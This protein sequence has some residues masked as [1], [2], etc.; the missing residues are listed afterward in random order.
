M[1]KKALITGIRGQDGAYLAKF[2]LNKGYTVIGADRRNSEASNW[3][4]KEI[5][6]YNKI[7]FVYLDLLEFSNI[8]EIL[9]EI[10]P[11][12]IYNLGAQT[13]VK[14][15]FNLPL[16]TTDINSL[17]TL[18]ILEA[19]RMLGL[20]SKFYQAST[21]EMFGNH[22]DKLLNEKTEFKP[23]SPYAVSK[24]FSHHITKQYRGTY[25]IFACSGILFNHESPLRGEEFVTRKIIKNLCLIKK[26]KI[27]NFKLGNIDS[28]RDWGYAKDY[29]ESMW[30][31]LNHKKPDDFVIA[32]G[33]SYTVKYFL[34]L[35]LGSL[36]IPYEWKKN[37]N[38]L[39][40]YSNKKMI[41]QTSTKTNMRPSDVF[42]LAGDS[43]K[44]H[45]VLKWKNKT[46]LKQLVMLMIEAEL[47]RI[48]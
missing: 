40:L 29:V 43:S 8:V 37:K 44:A 9:K 42:H 25:G 41:V 15:S 6:V 23:E 39:C 2:L 30:K 22:G 48:K 5:G 14:A 7:K 3:R 11:N 35:A 16:L 20:K 28:K 10:K 24:L 34:E 26:G 45:K 27:K 21:S 19:I 36:K 47:N 33:K 4:L 17:G 31:I 38:G 1:K 46:S 32:S 13:F 12:E 18:R